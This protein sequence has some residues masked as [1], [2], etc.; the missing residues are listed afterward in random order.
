MI[1]REIKEIL[2]ELQEQIGDL[3]RRQ[4]LLMENQLLILRW[5]YAQGKATN[6][7]DR[8]DKLKLAGLKLKAAFPEI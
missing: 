8:L 3:Q 5:S 6:R 2:G 7:T 1:D 4:E